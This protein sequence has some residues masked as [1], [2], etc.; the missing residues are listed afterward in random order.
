[1]TGKQAKGVNENEM[2]SGL[3]KLN[4]SRLEAQIY[5]ALL[6]EGGLSGYQLAKKINISRPSIYNAL[7]HMYEKGMISL[8]PDPSANYIAEKPAVL[9]QKLACEY[10]GNAQKVLKSLEEFERLE[11]EE[12]FANF[13]GFETAVFKT[14]DLLCGASQSVYMNMDFDPVSFQEEFQSLKERGV[15]VVLFS[16]FDLKQAGV[17]F[18]SHRRKRGPDD[19]PSRLMLVVD[20]KKALVADFNRER[21]SWMGTTTN[22]RLMVSIITEHIH[23][24]I[25]LLRLRQKFGEHLFDEGVYIHTGFENKCAVGQKSPDV[26][27][28]APHEI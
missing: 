23:N 1:M 14:K 24:D 22:N 6:D 2:V 28:E 27:K 10:T 5:M 19:F 26:G 7:D 9:F 8:V 12:K 25:Y 16:F 15:R 3:E 4:F 20:G 11:P 18:Y 13:K 17:E 21:N